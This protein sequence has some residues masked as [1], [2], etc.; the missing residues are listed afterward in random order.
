MK[1]LPVIENYA[2][3]SHVIKESIINNAKELLDISQKYS[4]GTLTVSE[5]IS[6]T[7][8]QLK[9][10]E[11]EINDIA[12]SLQKDPDADFYMSALEFRTVYGFILGTIDTKYN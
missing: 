3:L 12:F 10:S 7:A 8:Y 5:Y 2:H 1:K 11:S 9:R 4:N 6:Q